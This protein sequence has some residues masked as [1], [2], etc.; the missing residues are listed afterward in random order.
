MAPSL[1][2]T[3]GLRAPPVALPLKADGGFNKENL[4]GYK[5]EKDVEIKGTDK[6]APVSY[7]EYLPVWDNE[8]ERYPPLTPFEHYDHGKDADPSF[9]ELLPEGVQV[10]QLTPFIGSEIHGV[11]LSQLSDKGKDQLALYVA[12]RRVVA[13]RD[14][15]FAS[16]PIQKAVDYAGYFGRHHIHQTSGA[17]KGFPEI[18]LVF[19]G[20]DDRTGETFLKQRTNTI[21]WHSDVT[22][23]KQ[24][25]GTTFLYAL[26]GPTTGGDTLFADMVQAYKRLSPGFRERLHGLKAV[27]S[28]LEQIHASLNGGGI[29]R[30]DPV[31]SEH[32]IVRTHPVTGEKALYVNPQF[33]RYIVGYKKEESDNLLK[34]LYDHIALSQDLQARIR[35]KA[36]TVVVWDNRVACHSA[37]FDW[38]DGQRRHIA[39]LTPQAE[40]P[41]ETPFEG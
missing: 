28:G 37:V 11:Q 6:V 14:Q 27:H 19:R 20:A 3:V 22:F 18:H 15:D 7:P 9:S 24:P 21:T 41:Y 4:I 10:D 35:W 32:P 25:P 39:R 12:Q 29:A 40:A 31:S 13:F 17:P 16:L 38:E 23:E 1:T 33:T 26:D 30:R 2:E 5:I 8:T 36:G 34:F